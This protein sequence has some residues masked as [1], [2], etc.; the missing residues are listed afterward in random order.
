[1]QSATFLCHFENMLLHY[2]ENICVFVSISVVMCVCVDA[3]TVQSYVSKY[4]LVE[5][6]AYTYMYVGVRLCNL[7]SDLMLIKPV[8]LFISAWLLWCFIVER[9]SDASQSNYST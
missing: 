8:L 6:Y 9:L 1:M 3:C 5:C 4:T 7:N 2:K